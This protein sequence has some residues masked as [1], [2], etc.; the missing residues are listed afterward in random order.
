MQKHADGGLRPDYGIDAPGAVRN[1]L[2]GGSVALLVWGLAVGGMLPWAE[3]VR[4]LRRMGAAWRS[5]AWVWVA[6]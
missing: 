3:L 2:I 4:P 1:L 6:T 5:A